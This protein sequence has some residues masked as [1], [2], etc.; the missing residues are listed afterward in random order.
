MV[1]IIIE[2]ELRFNSLAKLLLL[3]KTWIKKKNDPDYSP[4][5]AIFCLLYFMHSSQY[6]IHCSNQNQLTFRYAEK[7]CQTSYHL[8]P[9]LEPLLLGS[10]YI[11]ALFLPLVLLKNILNL[12]F[13]KLYKD[14]LLN[15]SKFKLS[16]FCFY[17]RIV[18][19]LNKEFLELQWFSLSI[20]QTSFLSS[21][22]SWTAGI[23]SKAREFQ[24]HLESRICKYIIDT[25]L[26][27]K[28]IGHTMKSHLFL[29]PFLKHFMLCPMK[30][31]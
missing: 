12:F 13:Q 10:P 3:L 11:L 16:F 23:N 27:T 6:T 4:T 5:H 17:I 14:N 19:W 21:L 7:Y 2:V 1:L 30:G 31:H 25:L 8:F 26:I 22:G 18:I 20:L 29:N 24:F 9:R 28:Q 15:F